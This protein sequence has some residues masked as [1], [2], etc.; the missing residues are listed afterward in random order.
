MENLN[1][2]SKE[3]LKDI[4][5]SLDRLKGKTEYWRLLIPLLPKETYGFDRVKVEEFALVGTK[6]GSASLKLLH[7]FQRKGMEVLHF[8]KML[9][10]I[11]CQG[12]LDCFKQPSEF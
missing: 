10:K 2:L 8:K 11:E 6:G 3:T 7:E 9:Q 5:Y 12:A 1:S 4:A